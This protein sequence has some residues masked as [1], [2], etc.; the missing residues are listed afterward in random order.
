MAD[1]Q[2]DGGDEGNEENVAP[3]TQTPHP[4]SQYHND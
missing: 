1:E 3:L 4:D 2:D